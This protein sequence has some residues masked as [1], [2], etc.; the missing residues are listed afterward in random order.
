MRDNP[1]P[2][3]QRFLISFL[4][5]Y[6]SQSNLFWYRNCWGWTVPIHTR[7]PSVW[8]L[9]RSKS[10]PNS[11]ILH[12]LHSIPTEYCSRRFPSTPRTP[13]LSPEYCGTCQPRQIETEASQNSKEKHAHQQSISD[14]SRPTGQWSWPCKIFCISLVTQQT[15]DQGFTTEFCQCMEPQTLTLFH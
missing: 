13:F 8:A 7:F 3:I 10:M 15:A 14:G 5:L 1:T 6:W 2:V 9:R 4:N 11:E 12:V